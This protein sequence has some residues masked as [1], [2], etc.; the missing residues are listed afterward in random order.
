MSAPSRRRSTISDTSVTSPLARPP[1]FSPPSTRNVSPIRTPLH[2][3]SNSE[4]NQYAGPTIR[5]VDDPGSD[6]YAKDPF[7]SEPSQILPPRNAPG[8][9]F[10]RRGRRV[11]DAVARLE[12]GQTL[13]PTP[14]QP[15][16]ALRH[17]AST[18]T[19]E[20]DTFAASSFAPSSRYSQ[21]TAS[22]VPG[23][24]LTEKGLD[25]LEEVTSQERS[26]IRAVSPSTNPST[27]TSAEAPSEVHALTPRPSAAS[28]AST[29]SANDTVRRRASSNLSA[30]QPSGTSLPHTPTSAGHQKQASS[31][32]NTPN[33]RPASKASTTQSLAFSE[34][35]SV[36]QQPTLPEPTLHEA[37]TATLASGVRVLYPAI[38]APSANSLWAESQ[39]LPT[40]TSRMNNHPSQVHHWSSQLSTIH[41][42]S[43]RSR[44]IERA[45]Q[46]FSARSQSQDG[47]G[48]S[49]RSHIP[50]RRGTVGS[51]ASSDNVSSDNASSDATASSVAIPL[52]LFSPVTRHSQDEK[53]SDS[54]RHDTITPLQSPPL[55]VK[56]SGYLR[57]YDSDSRSTRSTTSSRPSSSQS[58]LATFITN[59]IPGWAR[60]YYRR[61]ERASLGAPDSSTDSSGESIRVPTAQ[62]G[63]T[64]TPSEGMPL[65]IYRPRNRPHERHS[66]PE[67]FSISDLGDQDV[68]VLGPQRR[69]APPYSPHLRQDRRSQAQLS[70]WKAPS[71]DE[72][73]G[74]MLFSR[75]NRQILLFCLGFI[76]PF[77]WMIAAVLPLPPSPDMLEA[78]PSQRDVE[79]QLARDF[80]PAG[81]KS[82]KK[83]TWW[84]NLN[85]VMSG[86]GT[87]LVGVIIALAILASRMS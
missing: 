14:S 81:D 79:N 77:A 43:E 78:T 27:P 73:L 54:E 15:K 5:L 64:T 16:K 9:A 55:R 69:L 3:R 57:R 46:S 39:D 4:S 53:D 23:S 20:A 1:N 70:A 51:V 60:M 45:S 52:P 11:S 66:Q 74:S 84:R 41:S 29:A 47:Y 87:L 82:F 36:S 24:F 40:I 34:I 12:A 8:Y 61:G 71:F 76:F 33:W 18:S 50:R 48:T 7:P 72:N 17:S 6:V 19:S 68:Y 63:R 75:Q 80:G 83:A 65:S 35:S 56:R 86:L 59:N 62:S 85:R 13:D 26:T 28:L 37:R 22:T 49:G 31:S 2:E 10:E 25:V 32:S 42:E 67:T 44:S 58:D 30:S 21:D 38:R